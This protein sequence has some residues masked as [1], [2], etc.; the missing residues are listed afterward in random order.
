[1][2]QVECV[3]VDTL[4]R[5]S[6]DNNRAEGDFVDTLLRES[7]DSNR[8]TVERATS[9]NS[10]RWADTDFPGDSQLTLFDPPC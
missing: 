3:F 1:M 7:R 10:N 5:E 2:K 9:L 6:R 8:W 4:L